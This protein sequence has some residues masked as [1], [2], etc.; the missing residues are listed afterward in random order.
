M[1]QKPCFVFDGRDVCFMFSLLFPSSSNY[2]LCSSFLS[3]PSLSCSLFRP[4]KLSLT[5]RLVCLITSCLAII[6]IL[7][8][9]LSPFS[10]VDS[11]SSHLGDNLSPSPAPRPSSG[12]PPFN[13][14]H[15]QQQQAVGDI[16]S[17]NIPMSNAGP[18]AMPSAMGMETSAPNT[19]SSTVQF[20][21]NT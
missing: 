18:S 14:Q 11:P 8:F 16:F 5:H 17:F 12:G 9:S 4:C 21:S 3:P 6:V 13:P 15:Q 10:Q 2:Y 7:Y 19:N 20:F 1:I